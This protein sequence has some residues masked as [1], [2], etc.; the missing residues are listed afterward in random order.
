MPQLVIPQLGLPYMCGGAG[1]LTFGLE[2]AGGG[3]A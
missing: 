2:P 1:L 3:A